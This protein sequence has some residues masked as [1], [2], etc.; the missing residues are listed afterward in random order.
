[1]KILENIDLKQHTTIRVG[2]TASLYFV[3]ETIDELMTVI[4][5]YS[6]ISIIGGG[7]NMLIN[8]REFDRV[9]DLGS[10]DI[11]ITNLG[12]GK[13]RV[14]ASVR[15]QHL[16]NTV[17]QEGYG[18]IEYLYSVPGLVGGAIVMNAGR[19]KQYRT[20]ISDYIVSVQVLQ[21][22]ELSE[23]AKEDCEF[24]YRSSRFKNTSCIVVSAV[25]EFPEMPIEESAK[26]KKERIALC[27]EKQDNSAPNFGSVFMECDPHIMAVAKKL[28][29]G[30]KKAHFS[31]KTE[32]WI[33]KEEGGTFSDVENAIKK[34][35]FLHKVFGKQCKREVIVWE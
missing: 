2:G 12:N 35:E 20:C 16:I 23:L 11:S 14:G 10:F 8:E 24:A 26:T 31:G 5:E 30:N 9:V 34:V 27:R 13:F 6:P 17:N 18:G 7:S 21:D 22:G 1:M 19:G 29:I 28:K 33:V 3:P 15:L 4:N 32:N 25:F